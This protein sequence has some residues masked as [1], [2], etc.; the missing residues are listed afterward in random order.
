MSCTKRLRLFLCEPSG[1]GFH[2]SLGTV[3]I[4]GG[5][6]TECK[7][8]DK[9]SAVWREVVESLRIELAAREHMATPAVQAPVVEAVYHCGQCGG[10]ECHRPYGLAD[11]IE[12]SQ[13]GAQS[14]GGAVQ[15]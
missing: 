13:C 11:I 15:H 4:H 8:D 6:V 3:E 5:K 9:D 7:I 14:Q 2:P 1:T 12:C 10:G